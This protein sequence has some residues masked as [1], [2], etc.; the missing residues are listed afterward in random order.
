[1]AT[2]RGR[3]FGGWQSPAGLVPPGLQSY[4]RHDQLPS[5]VPKSQEALGAAH[6]EPWSKMAR[7]PRGLRNDGRAG[8]LQVRK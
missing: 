2:S 1:M 6:W 3:C 8:G 5:P 4:S 7:S